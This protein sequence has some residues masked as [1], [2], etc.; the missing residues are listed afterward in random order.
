MKRILI[1]GGGSIGERHLR[2]FQ[3]TSRADVSLCEIRQELRGVLAARYALDRV[4][5]SLEDALQSPWDAGVICTPAHLHIPMAKQFAER[6]IAVLI[7]KPLSTT[8]EGIE[9]FIQVVETKKLPVSVAYVLRQHPA[10]KAM[11]RALDS[12]K[13]GTPVQIVMTSGQHFPFYRPAYR[14]TYYTR[15]E[16]G[17]GAIQDALT[18]TLN[19]AEWLVGPITRLVADAGHQVLEGV[20]VEDTVHVLTRHA[21]VLGSFSLNQHQP[22]NETTLTVICERAAL[23]WESH[24][25]RW[26]SCDTA[27]QPWNVEETFS[28]ERDDLFISQARLFLDQ[29][30]NAIGPACSIREA[31][32]TLKVN[33]A[34]LKS[35]KDKAWITP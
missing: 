6:N 15:H 18:H 9:E 12:G 22:P 25:N 23:R 4:F 7:E 16:T 17:G 14:E 2:C 20:D 30:E 1:V 35:L 31:W 8:F 32:Q 19:A 5:P 27:G 21:N 28:L 33:L 13:F 26:L 34:A 11:K 10:L 24:N 29:M 3:R